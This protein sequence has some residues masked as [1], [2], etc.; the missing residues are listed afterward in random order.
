MSLGPTNRAWL[1]YILM[2]CPLLF[3][4]AA[5]ADD[6]LSFNRDVRPILSENCF[7][8]HG[9]DANAR[10]AKL[11]LDLRESA[12][13]DRGGYYAIDLKFPAESEIVRRINTDDPDDHMPPPDSG[14]FLTEQQR[15]VLA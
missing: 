14:K 13:E 12:T 9:P 1:Q 11:R 4:V 2:G 8:C 5:R 3:S 6:K 10:K 15:Q 7:K